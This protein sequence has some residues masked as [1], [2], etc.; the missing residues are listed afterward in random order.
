MIVIQGYFDVPAEHC[1]AFEALVVPMQQASSAE[2]G[3]V[4]YVFSRDLETPGRYRLAEAWESEE[5]LTAHFQMPHMATLQAGLKE[6][7]PSGS[8][9]KHT[10]A[11][12]SKMM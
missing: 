10:V 5:A 1:A 9:W 3:C 2:A 7:K 6:I 4:S 12:S 8:V 11:D